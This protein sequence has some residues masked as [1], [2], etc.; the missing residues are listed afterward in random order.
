MLIAGIIFAATYILV[1]FQNIPGIHLHRP[2]AALLG[3]VAMVSFGVISMDQAYRLVDFD[4][5]VFILGMMIIIGYLEVTGFFERIEVRILN[6]AG[7]TRQLLCLI[8]TSSGILSALFMNDTICLMLTPVVLSIVTRAGLPPAPYLIALA[9]S[10]NIGSAM[11]PMGNPQNMIIAIHSKIP[12]TLFTFALLPVSAVG[13]WLN[14]LVIKKLYPVEFPFS[15][16][17]KTKVEFNATEDTSPTPAVYAF[18]KPSL[19]F[20]A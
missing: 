2:A 17:I 6:K 1:S 11:T 13:L 7:D 19:S 3:A 12:F 15:K 8:I 18:G 5:L 9:T 20:A 16:P 4:T 10:S 14:Y